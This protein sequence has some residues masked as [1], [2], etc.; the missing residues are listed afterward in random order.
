M[1]ARCRSSAMSIRCNPVA[2]DQR[3]AGAGLGGEVG[4]AQEVRGG[5]RDVAVDDAPAV[6][7]PDRLADDRGG[8]GRAALV[9]AVALSQAVALLVLITHVTTTHLPHRD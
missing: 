5:E 2:V 7:G 8:T 1:V 6:G 9:I 3:E 4:G